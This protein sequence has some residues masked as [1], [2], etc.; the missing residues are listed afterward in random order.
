MIAGYRARPG[1][2]EFP[3]WMRVGDLMTG[4]HET[5]RQWFSTG[6]AAYRWVLSRVNGW[7]ELSPVPTAISGGGQQLGRSQRERTQR[8]VFQ[9]Q[10]YL[11]FKAF[12][13][14]RLEHK[15]P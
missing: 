4:H 6:V 8:R 15:A 9:R 5:G 12:H 11:S 14:V 1:V 13:V 10:G 7:H 3:A 2:V